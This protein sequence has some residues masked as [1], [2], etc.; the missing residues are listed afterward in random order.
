MSAK[1]IVKNSFSERAEG[2]MACYAGMEGRT[3]EQK[4]LLSR[5][6]CAL[7]LLEA[8]VAAPAMVLDAGCGSGEMAARLMERGFDVQGVDI[9]EP[10]VHLAGTR[11][12]TERFRVSDIEALPFADNTF[13]A[14]L[15]LGVIEYLESD[16]Q[17]LREIRRVLKPSGIAILATPNAMAP[18]QIIDRALC[19]GRPNTGITHR[20][21]VPARWQR[22]L[23]ASGFQ[24]ES[25]IYHGWGWYRSRLGAIASALSDFAPQ[26][27]LK[28]LAAEQ[29]IR[30]RAIK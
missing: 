9:A 21:Y 7:D 3:L 5:Q 10:M 17:A 27:R 28:Y 13:D 8:A 30:V 11:F 20:R 15:S 22:L 19:F 23:Q 16:V 4:N 6:R 1:E 14:V 18:M 26:P 25:S 29:I 24:C 2:W 12:G